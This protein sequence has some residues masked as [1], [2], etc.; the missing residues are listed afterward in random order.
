MKR[1]VQFHPRSRHHGR[2]DFKELLAASHDLKP[3]VTREH[4]K[5]GSIDF[6]NPAA[7]KALN[8]ALLRLF[9]G[10]EYWDIPEGY[11]CPPIPGRAEYIHQIA[12]LIKDDVSHKNKVV[13]LDIGVGANCIYPIIA[14]SQY[15]W[16][17]IGSDIDPKSVASAQEIVRQYGFMQKRVEI[18]HQGNPNNIFAGI[19]KKNERIDV[20]IC[21]PP[22]YGS[23]E[24]LESVTRRKNKNLHEGIEDELAKNFGGQSAEL[25]CEGGEVKF[26]TKMIKQSEKYQ[27]NCMWFTSL[28][29]QES[30]LKK[31]YKVLKGV[32]AR[33]IK[34]IPMNFGNKKSRILAWRF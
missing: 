7:V 12:D 14:A 2:Y 4:A 30:H 5:D 21:N 24:E 9:Y 27:N 26:I 19:I 31:F 20:A 25:Y 15:E 23:R 3:F 34:T 10:V 33:E 8:V 22:F 1:F 13:C 32:E 17:C 29:S 16:H 6:S 28:V 18:R 11:L